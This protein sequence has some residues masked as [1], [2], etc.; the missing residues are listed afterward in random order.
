MRIYGLGKSIP[1]LGKG[2][3]GIEFQVNGKR[4]F[5]V[6]LQNVLHAPEAP[7]NLLSLSRITDAG[8][9]AEFKG[10]SVNI[11]TPAPN[12]IKIA[13]GCKSGRLYVMNATVA[14]RHV[15]HAHTAKSSYTWDEWHQ[16]LGHLNMASVKMLKSKNMVQNM[17]VDESVEAASQC[18]AC[19]QAKHHVTKFPTE[20]ETTI[21]NIGEL[22]V[23]DV[24]GPARTESIGGYRYFITFTD[25][26]TRRTMTYFGKTKN[27]VL[28]K[29]R[30][31]KSFVE[32]QTGKRLKK[33]RVD[34]GKEYVNKAMEDYLQE[35]GILLETT[36]PYSPAQ[37]GIAERL[38]RT[39]V[40]RAR[41]MLIAKSLPKFLWAEAIAYAT[42]LKNR[43]P[44]RALKEPITPEEAFFGQKPDVSVIQEFGT[45]CWVLIPDEQRGKLDAK[46]A[47]RIFI[48]MADGSK[49]W[50]YYEPRTRYIGKSR[51][52]IFET[53]THPTTTASDIEIVH[54][55]INED[56]GSIIENQNDEHEN[57]HVSDDTS[58][59][60]TAPK[61]AIQSRQPSGRLADKPRLNYRIL[62]NPYARET[63]DAQLTNEANIAFYGIASGEEPTSYKEAC[64]SMDKE[65]WVKAMDDEI[66]Q[67]T[68]LETYTLE[69]LPNDRKVVGCKWVYR[70]KRDTNGKIAKYKARL[71]AQGFSQVA[72]VDYVDTFAPVIRLESLRVLFA[73][74][75][76]LDFEIDQADVVG[77][78]LNSKLEEIIYMKQP[79][80]YEDG[81]DRV[82]LLLKSLYGLKQSG[83]AWNHT[84]NAFLIN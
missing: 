39:L 45:N 4:N 16:R 35:E 70:V 41:A 48:G 56:K 51:N 64:E 80:G 42:Y 63:K 33:L 83:R 55:I 78:Y 26:K 57:D 69:D 18:E 19:V 21:K 40:E 58:N 54:P 10:D 71:V 32:T 43:S 11:K 27:I 22:T 77:A 20:S 73:I 17:S 36:A 31:Y 28:E 67:L 29:F 66:N 76:I 30:Y 9:H 37:N 6:T 24:W 46:S 44:T 49:A 68:T 5:R 14:S 8:F 3:I 62:H 38:N 12:S 82:W 65:H 74:A 15:E 79:E 53:P 81:T 1:V 34:N 47:K 59:A 7:N 52:I 23:S 75:I 61:P 2:S 72:G 25:A 50:R 60:N 84:I 13:E